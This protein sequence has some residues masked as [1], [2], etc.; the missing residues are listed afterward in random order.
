MET[1]TD[2][3]KLRQDIID[4]SFQM[5]Q[6]VRNNHKEQARQLKP[7]LDELIRKYLN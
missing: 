4:L 6:C 5:T 2:D 7:K 1:I 3:K